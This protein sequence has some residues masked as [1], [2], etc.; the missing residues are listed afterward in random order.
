MPRASAQSLNLPFLLVFLGTPPYSPFPNRAFLLTS[1]PHAIGDSLICQAM[2]QACPRAKSKSI[3]YAQTLGCSRE[4]L[5]TFQGTVSRK[6]PKTREPS[7]TDH[8]P[9]PTCVGQSQNTCGISGAAWLCVWCRCRMNTSPVNMFSLQ[10][11]ASRSR[12]QATLRPAF[13]TAP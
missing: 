5:G 9:T 6:K 10:V 3:C 7:P 11:P 4:R 13:N 2:R 1:A 8:K 12:A